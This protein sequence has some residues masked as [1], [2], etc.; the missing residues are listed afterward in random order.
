MCYNGH[1]TLLFGTDRSTLFFFSKMKLEHKDLIKYIL[2]ISL[3]T[4][5][6]F[7]KAIWNT[8]ITIGSLF[9]YTL[10]LLV[11]INYYKIDT[12]AINSFIYLI[13]YLMRNW[14]YFFIVFFIMHFYDST[15]RFGE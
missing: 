7:M 9:A 15:W 1:P 2:K 13:Q 8:A 10:L 12:S 4:I 3:L 14:N 11:L 6:I 5:G